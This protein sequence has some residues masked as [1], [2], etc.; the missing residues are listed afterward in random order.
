[1]ANGHQNN[2]ANN[3]TMNEVAKAAGVSVAT[4]SRVINGNK[5]V[6]KKLEQRVQKAIQELNY[7]PSSL[8]RSFK[9]QETRLIGLI[10]PLLDHPFFSRLAQVMEQELFK[11]NYRAIICNTE[12]NEARELEYVELLLR[13]RIDGVIVNSATE[14]T[15]YLFDLKRQ[16][17]PCVLIDR[18]VEQFDCSKVFSDNSLGGY[19]G[20]K[21]LLELGH[22]RIKVVAPFDF[23]EPTQHRIRGIRE[24]MAEFGYEEPSDMFITTSDHS[25]EMGVEVG[26]QLAQMDPR[27]TA[28]FG[29]SDVTAIGVMHAL[30]QMNLCIPKDISVMGY[31]NIPLSGYMLPSMTTIDQPI[32]AMGKTAVRVLLNHIQNASKQ[33]ER[34][35]LPTQL[36]VRNSTAAPPT[37]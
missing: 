23:A 17:V 6:S 28:I 31:D 22:R 37:E 8:A 27:P 18:N 35:V 29:L 16:N 25:F 36:I 33:S 32:N 2:H 30:D 10:I 5:G 21:Y 26:L 19:L 24:A 15:D 7:H 11:N 34:A 12:E 13:Q 4:V 14:H 20:M 9:M 1:M 3:P